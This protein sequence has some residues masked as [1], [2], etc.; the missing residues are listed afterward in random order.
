MAGTVAVTSVGVF[1][2]RGGW[3]L[4]PTN[5]S[6]QLTVGGISTK[7]R[8][9]DGELREREILHVTLTFDHDVIDGA[10]AARFTQS[11]G[12]RTEGAD[13]LDEFEEDRPGFDDPG[14]ID[15]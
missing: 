1:G 8:Y 6:L 14:T 5:Y 12:H 10:P 4:T 2:G 9:A 7:P 11:L 13:G 3:G 15:K